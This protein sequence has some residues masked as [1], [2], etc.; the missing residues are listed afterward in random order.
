M[1]KRRNKKINLK[2]EHSERSAITA[3]RKYK[4]TVFRKLFSDRKNLLS[5]YN[6]INGTAYMDASQLEI[7]TLDN[8]I[9]MG[10]KND[11][12]FIINTNLFL[13]EHQSTYNP[14][15]PLRDLFYI[16]G[17]YQ[18]LVDLTSLYT[19]TRLRIPTPNFIVFY[20]GT[21]KNED[22]WVEY[23]SESYENM[24]GEPNLELKVIILNINVGHNK[25]LMEE[26][27]TLREYAQY[28]AKVRRY[29]EEMEL[30]TAVECAVSES[31]Q[32]GI[33]KEFLQKN[34]AEVI[35]MSIFEY[36]EE[37]EKR[38]LRKAEYEAG[39]AEGVMKTKKETVISLA[40]MGLS[41]Q[42]IAQGVKV[43]EKTVYKWL[44]EKKNMKTTY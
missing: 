33:L 7:V 32:E 1:A 20:N 38:K 10:M 3:N 12:A 31:I 25:K 22:R 40:E 35:A 24:S 39:M 43:E 19:S 16:S 6:A 5:L 28:V 15:M 42:Q 21:E 34:R 27:Q 4:D 13:Y 30:N 17:E 36:N 2:R 37:E 23:L 44:N 8:A 29:S 14:N 26:C 18:K 41:V 11:L 9:Y